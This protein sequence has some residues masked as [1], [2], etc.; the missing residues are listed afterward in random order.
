[1]DHDR[2]FKELLTTFLWE[3]LELF[4]P[5]VVACAERESLRFLDKEVFTDVTSGERH[6]A[7]LVAILR[8]REEET[9]LLV[10]IENQAS[11]QPQF[12]K[13]MFHYFARLRELHDMPILPIVVF[14]YDKPRRAEPDNFQ[15][16]V[17]GLRVLDFRFTVVQLNRRVP[18][19]RMAR[20]RQTSESGSICLDGQNANCAG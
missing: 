17:P 16:K 14:S 18:S 5:E 15:V 7:D 10:H 20:L 13:R 9:C 4:A 19:G 11:K 2:L 6:E 1:M 8:L 12:G 3:F